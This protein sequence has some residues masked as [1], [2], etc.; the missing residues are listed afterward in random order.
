MLRERLEHPIVGKVGERGLLGPGEYVFFLGGKD[1]TV[2]IDGAR[3]IDHF[4]KVYPAKPLSP[5]LALLSIT[6]IVVLLTPVGVFLAAAARFGGEQRDRRLA[7]LRLIGADRRT[8]ARIA[9]GEALAGSVLGIVLGGAFFLVGR[10]SVETFD[11][12]G[13]SVFSA[14]LS[15]QPLLAAITLVAV[16]AL[17]IAVSVMAMGQVAVEPLGVMRRAGSPRRRL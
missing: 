9:A 6:G 5:A 10:R 12:Q 13:L 17:C 8:T 3:R 15:P 7:A 14:D 16:P 1:M 2:G 4:G 11:I